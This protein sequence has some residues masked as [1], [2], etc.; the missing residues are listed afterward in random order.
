MRVNFQHKLDFAKKN[1]FVN[2]KYNESGLCR[3]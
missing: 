1:I 3:P 2:K